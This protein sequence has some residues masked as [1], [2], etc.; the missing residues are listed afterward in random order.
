[1]ASTQGGPED[2]GD[3]LLGLEDDDLNDFD[4]LDDF[5]DDIDVA[6]QQMHAR[7]ANGLA[8]E[9]RKLVLLGWLQQLMFQRIM[10]FLRTRFR[11]TKYPKVP[12]S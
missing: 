2:Y 9:N 10:L 12:G 7:A 11:R 1:M 6:S 3:L 4:G 8:H 5:G